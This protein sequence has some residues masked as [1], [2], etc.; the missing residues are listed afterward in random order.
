MSEKHT[1]KMYIVK[2]FILKYY[3]TQKI[4]KIFSEKYLKDYEIFFEKI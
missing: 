3:I 1:E 4:F 2:Q